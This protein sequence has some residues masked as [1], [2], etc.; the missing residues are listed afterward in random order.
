[1]EDSPFLGRRQVNT[2]W[3]TPPSAASPRG[4][5]TTATATARTERAK[6][7]PNGRRWRVGRRP[8]TRFVCTGMVPIGT[9]W[10]WDLW[11][12]Y[13]YVIHIYY[14]FFGVHHF[15]HL[16]IDHNCDDWYELIWEVLTHPQLKL[17]KVID[18][19]EGISYLDGHSTENY[20]PL[21]VTNS[22]PW[23][24]WPIEIDG[25]PINSMAIFHGKTVSHNQMVI[26]MLKSWLMEVKSHRSCGVEH[27]LCTKSREDISMKSLT[28]DGWLM[29]SWGIYLTNILDN[30]QS[31]KFVHAS[32]QTS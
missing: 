13:R 14:G 4:V 8:G 26:G 17:V 30:Y 2:V 15:V 21:V 16:F 10:C 18:G 1:M 28:N 5:A 31:P 22:S 3:S 27:V 24:R 11:M 23:Y 6:T 12:I 19:H 9:H 32:H 25:L 29:I 7:A 20:Y